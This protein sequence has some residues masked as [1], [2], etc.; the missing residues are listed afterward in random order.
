VR[1]DISELDKEQA[2]EAWRIYLSHYNYPSKGV[3]EHRVPAEIAAWLSR[4]ASAERIKALEGVVQNLMLEAR[5]RT[6]RGTTP[7]TT[8]IVEMTVPDRVALL[9]EADQ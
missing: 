9:K 8:N 1:V 4:K 3:D 2:G 5:A 6:M 7:L